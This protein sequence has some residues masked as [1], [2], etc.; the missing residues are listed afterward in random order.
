VEEDIGRGELILNSSRR[1]HFAS[2]AGVL[3]RLEI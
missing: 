1:N 2:T 3:A